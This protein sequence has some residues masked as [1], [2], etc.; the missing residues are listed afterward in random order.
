[1]LI[2]FYNILIYLHYLIDYMRISIVLR[3]I[4]VL[5][6]KNNSNRKV[7]LTKYLFHR[8]PANS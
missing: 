7:Q 3:E 8:R 4:S 2:W 6:N 1:M 5:S